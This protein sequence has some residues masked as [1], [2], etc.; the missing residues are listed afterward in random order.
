MVIERPIFV[1]GSNRLGIHGAGAAKFARNHFGAQLGVGEGLTGQSYALPTKHDPRSTLPYDDVVESVFRFLATAKS[2]PD[3]SFFLTPVGTGFAGFSLAEIAPLFH[4]APKNVLLPGAFQS[5]F[6]FPNRL[7]VAG[8][9]HHPDPKVWL[10]RVA[11][12]QSKLHAELVLCMDSGPGPDQLLSLWG[13]DRN[14]P[15]WSFPAERER[16]R[17]QA[18]SVRNRLLAS[19][20][21]H[22]LVFD[23]G[24][25]PELAQLVKALESEKITVVVVSYS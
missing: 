2:H 5:H 15:V 14:I 19:F 25:N 3:L 8:G 24:C 17:A 9:L 4:G 6:R 11:K 12:A 23:N 22:V 10:Q 1:F 7:L 20:V 16:L 21:T 18:F 13:E